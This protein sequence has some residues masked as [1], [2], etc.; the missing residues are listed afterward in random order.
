MVA[1]ETDFLKKSRKRPDAM[2]SHGLR[3]RLLRGGTLT[4]G[5][6]MRVIS[7][8]LLLIVLGTTSTG[9]SLFKKN[10]NGAPGPINNGAAPVKFPG[11]RDPL[12]GEVPPLPTFP[13]ANAAPTPSPSPTV[14]PTSHGGSTLAGT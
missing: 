6:F 1:G 13:P 3:G 12:L 9:C 7:C 4:R 14:T 11:A 10:T 2:R 8:M 5:T